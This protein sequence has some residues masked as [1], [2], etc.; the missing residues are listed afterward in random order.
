MNNSS[1]PRS[2]K[3]FLFSAAVLLGTFSISLNAGLHDAVRKGDLVG[4]KKLLGEEGTDLLDQDDKGHTALHIAVGHNKPLIVDYL[5][6]QSRELATIQ[7]NK[8]QTPLH[9]AARGK[10]TGTI[11]KLVEAAPEA[12]AMVDVQG[13]NPLH[14][15]AWYG[16][17]E[18]MKI[19]ASK[20][21]QFTWEAVWA[22]N[23]HGRNPIHVLAMTR[24][25]KKEAKEKIAE[26][27]FS[28][29]PGTCGTLWVLDNYGRIPAG[30]GLF[31]LN[32]KSLT[33]FYKA[34][35]N[36]ASASS[37]N[38]TDSA[39][40]SKLLGLIQGVPEVF[41]YSP[42]KIASSKNRHFTV[43]LSQNSQ[44]HS[45]INLHFKDGADVT[46]EPN[47]LYQL[48]SWGFN[49][50]FQVALTTLL[51]EAGI[52]QRL[53]RAQVVGIDS[54]LARIVRG[55][56]LPYATK[57]KNLI[58]TKHL[59]KLNSE[60]INGKDDLDKTPL[61]SLLSAITDRPHGTVRCNACTIASAL[62]KAGAHADSF[63]ERE[64]AL[65]D[66]HNLLERAQANSYRLLHAPTPQLSSSNAGVKRL[67]NSND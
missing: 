51:F 42:C 59:L 50:D 23:V 43:E 4:L 16:N 41:L 37:N 54:V 6:E 56:I 11:E 33:H 7:N 17:T 48:E 13:G 27:L 55:G 2:F 22:Q 26:E 9:I 36:E 35:K 15:A 44:L 18:M 3:T 62:I 1:Q 60:P 10:H 34:L 63:S 12:T 30:Y 19:C 39:F 21:K 32:T 53:S 65:L 24:N 49:S 28:L 58:L 46:L 14:Y 67:R 31:P 45:Y 64:L 47:I 20:A 38:H 8:G 29:R 25:A 57:V 61:S 40:Y 52:E 66:R 5:L